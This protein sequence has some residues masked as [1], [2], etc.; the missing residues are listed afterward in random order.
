MFVFSCKIKIPL[1]HFALLLS[2]LSSQ[3]GKQRRM[4]NPNNTSTLTQKTNYN[5]PLV[6]PKT[7]ARTF[8]AH[9]WTP[10]FSCFIETSS[11]FSLHVIV[12][13]SVPSIMRIRLRSTPLFQTPRDGFILAWFLSTF[14]YLGIH[15]AEIGIISN[16]GEV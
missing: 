9:F 11:S 14:R 4:V 1:D 2:V 12:C 13:C 16:R 5:Y 8:L 15:S 7:E 6:I 10:I 3:S